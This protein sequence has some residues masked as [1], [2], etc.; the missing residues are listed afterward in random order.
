[1][2]KNKRNLLQRV[3]HYVRR[4][5]NVFFF[6][7]AIA[8]GLSFVDYWWNNQP[9]FTG[10][11]LETLAWIDWVKQ[12]KDYDKDIQPLYVNV[13]YDKQ[14]VNKNDEYGMS[15]GN[16]DIT[17]R[18]KLLR[19]LK[20]LHS[21]NQYKYIFLDV[22]FEDEYQTDVDSSLFSEIAGMRNIVVARHSNLKSTN[23]LLYP[24][25]AL[26]DYLSTIFSTGFIRYEYS[27]Q[28]EPTIPL[29]AYKEL[30]HKNINKHLFFY[31]CD[32]QLCYNSL[33]LNLG[34]ENFQEYDDDNVKVYYNMGSDIL[35]NYDADDLAVLSKGKCI[36]VGDMI[37]DTHDT[38]VGSKPGAMITF[39]AFQALMDGKHLVSYPVVILFAVLYLGYSLYQFRASSRWESL[40][41]KMPKWLQKKWVYFIL[42]FLKSISFWLIVGILL[43]ICFDVSTSII[44]PSV[45]FTIQRTIIKYIRM[46]I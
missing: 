20:M 11:K 26:S 35:D 7:I 24:K 17:D 4:N 1:M 8:I 36:I 38:Y 27:Y 28:G 33:F 19:F 22:R 3:F 21:T 15:V 16:I 10:E 2:A 14:L 12:K 23:S 40:N 29:F 46:R 34:I 37:E 44:I 45:W 30:T 25:S 31:T 41:K 32:G 5:K 6:S 9:L 18:T 43:K 42:S 13:S 39:A